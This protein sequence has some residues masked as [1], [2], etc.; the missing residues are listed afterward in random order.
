[1]DGAVASV[2][3]LCYSSRLS[4]LFFGLGTLDGRKR[5]EKDFES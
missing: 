3:H 5:V 2:H 1:M 4:L